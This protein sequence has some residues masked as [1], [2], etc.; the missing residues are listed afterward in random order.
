MDV[1]SLP[2]RCEYPSTSENE[3]YLVTAEGSDTC[4]LLDTATSAQGMAVNELIP[5]AECLGAQSVRSVRMGEQN[6]Y[7]FECPGSLGE[8]VRVPVIQYAETLK[9]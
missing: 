8:F 7:V 1:L 9:D 3:R 4:S 6:Y 5:T 2:M